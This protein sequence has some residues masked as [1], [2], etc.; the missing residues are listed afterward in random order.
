VTALLR[1]GFHLILV[2]VKNRTII[3]ASFVPGSICGNCVEYAFGGYRRGIG[4]FV[5]SEYG[6]ESAG[7]HKE[8]HPAT[9]Q[10]QGLRTRRKSSVLSPALPRTRRHT[11]CR[12]RR[13]SG[14]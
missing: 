6:K 8:T 2:P 10:V 4:R 5:G 3:M 12:L 13:A 11:R 1:Q 7:R 9:Y 14:A